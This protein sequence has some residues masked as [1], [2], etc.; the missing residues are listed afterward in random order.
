MA[1]VLNG[2]PA[3]GTAEDCGDGAYSLAGLEFQRAVPDDPSPTVERAAEIKGGAGNVVFRQEGVEFPASYSQTAVNVVASKY[4]YGDAEG[5]AGG[6]REGGRE[7]SMRALVDRVAGPVAQW[8]R[9]DGYFR[10]LADAD[11]FEADLKAILVGQYA[12]FNSP[13]WFNVGLWDAYGVEGDATAWRWNDGAR[14]VAPLGPGE[15][16]RYP[17]CS[18]CF[19]QGVDDTLASIM[20][21]AKAEAM[22][23]KG[24]SGTGADLSPLRSTREKLTGGG[25]PSGPVSFFRVYDAV[26]SVVKSGGKTRRAARMQ[27]LRVD[28]PD[29]MEFAACKVK[30][31]RKA[32]A[33]IA[34]GWSGGMTGADDEA[35]SSVAFQNTNVSIRATDEFMRKASGDDPDPTFWTR[36]VVGGRPVEAF[37]ARAMLDAFASA[38]WECGDPGMQFHDAANRW[39]TAADTE[40]IESSNPCSEY[41]YVNDSACNLASL[42]LTRFLRPDGSFDCDLFAHVVRVVLTAQE[43]MVD[44]ASYPT[45]KIARNSHEHRPLGI[46]LADLGAMLM[47]LGLPYDSDEGR[48]HAGAVAALMQAVAA[49]TSAELAR[50]KGPYPAYAANRGS[51]LRV[52]GMHAEAAFNEDA[53]A[54]DGARMPWLHARRWWDAA[55]ESGRRHG[56]R[57]AQLS[58]MAPT[59]TI[60]FMMDCRTTGI[61]PDI[62]LVKYKALAGGGTMR[63]VND[64]VGA[65]LTRLGCGP[66]A[67][68]AIVAHVESTGA[69]EG[70]PGLKDEHLAVFDCAFAA[71]PGGR[72]ISLDGHLK[73]MAAIQPFVSGAIS[74]TC[75]LPAEATVADVRNAYVEAWRLGLKAVAIYR[76]G[77]KGV[78]PLTTKRAGS[79]AETPT[80]A[81]PTAPAP[82]RP[83][84]ERLPTTRRAITHKFDIQGHEGYVN[85]GLY[86]DGRPGE[87][88]ITMAKE[89]STVGG[90]MDVLGTSI[91]IGLQYGVPIDVLVTKLSHVRFEPSGFTGNPDVPI[92]KSIVDY[93]FRWIG[94][95]FVD[96]YREANAPKRET[97][98]PA[99]VA[100]AARPVQ[101]DSPACP[102]CGGITVRAGTCYACVAC[103]S[104]TGCS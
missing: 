95:E 104:T 48:S 41:M 94:M 38:A 46:G 73:M 1:S 62:A 42:R 54:F 89:G 79:E 92:A 16:Y 21:L 39:N 101:D 87:L 66:D 84:R 65:A 18:A 13:V 50:A 12:A 9:E 27:T 83:S 43:I 33:L 44:R 77:S 76:D 32:R 91:S 17:M 2:S 75:N 78:Q 69:A 31:D 99:A 58:V 70:A 47:A 8:G 29:V 72:S 45:E 59:G 23:F 80:P 28:H 88:F 26:A 14:D 10:S 98:A 37:D 15:A 53:H 6:P 102:D 60:S 20:D 5:A 103:G 52:M 3:D 36:S 85:V 51:M 34:A 19:I 81:A 100:G 4:F 25:R 63:L 67:S 7:R 30:E 90:L 96:G 55:L 56:Y 24:G 40:T 49:W 35:Y 64:G 22:L 68:A 93:I 71:N 11:A 74:K 86:P 82:S 97:R 61:E 57:N